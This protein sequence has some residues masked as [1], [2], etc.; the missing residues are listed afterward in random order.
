MMIRMTA[1]W[2]SFAEMKVNVERLKRF[3]NVPEICGAALL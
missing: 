3:C 2:I 1:V